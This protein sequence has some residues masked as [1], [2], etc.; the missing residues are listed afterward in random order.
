MQSMALDMS[1]E[2]SVVA[3]LTNFKPLFGVVTNP[4][5]GGADWRKLIYS[6]K[7]F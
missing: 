3:S 7:L 6:M 1:K 4:A 5:F 2:E